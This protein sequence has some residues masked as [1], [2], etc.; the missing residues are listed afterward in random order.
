MKIWRRAA[1]LRLGGC[2][3]ADASPVFAVLLRLDSRAFRLGPSCIDRTRMAYARAAGNK[4]VVGAQQNQRG[5]G[6]LRP[7]PV[8]CQADPQMLHASQL[9]ERAGRNP[10]RGQ[11]ARTP[12]T[13][14]TCRRRRACVVAAR[15]RVLPLTGASMMP[16]GHAQVS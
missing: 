13:Q 4:V 14:S 9:V 1:H 16:G 6:V 10:A 11:C 2:D 5:A 7:F 12:W 3:S 15:A 8:V